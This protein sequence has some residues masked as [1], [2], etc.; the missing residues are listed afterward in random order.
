MGYMTVIT[1]LNDGWHIAKNN[2]NELIDRIEDGMN[3]IERFGGIPRLSKKIVTKHNIK[4]YSSVI[5]VNRSFHADDEN[6]LYVG[7]NNMKNLTH[8]DQDL[9][10]EQI[11]CRIKDIS[12]AQKLL[13]QSKENMYYQIAEHIVKTCRLQCN[14]TLE[15]KTEEELVD[16][17]NRYVDE[18][19]EAS[20]GTI[21]G[22][23]LRKAIKRLR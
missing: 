9:S 15:K 18:V 5:S 6:L 13:E 12:H 22:K 8:T 21:S 4:N 7:M 2:T 1:I 19:V 10:V 11:Q 17:I 16:C 20:A 14:I 3:G 23:E